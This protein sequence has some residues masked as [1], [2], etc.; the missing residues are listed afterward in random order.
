MYDL[1]VKTLLI[2][3]SRAGRGGGDFGSGL[4]VGVMEMGVALLC[5]INLNTVHGID[6]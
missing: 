6:A 4:A 5:C 3:L 1:M 2:L